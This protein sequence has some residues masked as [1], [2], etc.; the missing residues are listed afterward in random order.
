M[1]SRRLFTHETAHRSHGTHIIFLGLIMILIVFFVY[2]LSISDF[3]QEKS[4]QLKS[5][6]SKTFS[7]NAVSKPLAVDKVTDYPSWKHKEI[8]S[9]TDLHVQLKRFEH[10]R[11]LQTSYG[12]KI[13]MAIKTTSLVEGN[14]LSF[15]GNFFI[16][17]LVKSMNHMTKTKSESSFSVTLLASQNDEIQNIL[18]LLMTSIATYTAD[19]S[20][21]HIIFD[22]SYQDGSYTYITISQLD[23]L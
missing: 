8:Q 13:T 9:L 23:L 5:S 21:Y 10:I 14:E 4:Y 16:G 22:P 17:N 11:L 12:N 15:F 3:D 1:S 18:F 19:K 20:N 2:L 6:L 7:G